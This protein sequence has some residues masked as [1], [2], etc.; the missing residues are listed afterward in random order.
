VA[1]GLAIAALGVTIMLRPAT[2]KAQTAADSTSVRQENLSAQSTA[3][4]HY[5]SPADRA[6]DALLIVRVMARSPTRDWPTIIH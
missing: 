5:A 1:A 3:E 6:S 4:H 2:A